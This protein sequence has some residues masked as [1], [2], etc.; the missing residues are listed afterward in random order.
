MATQAKNHKQTI[1]VKTNEE[2]PEPVEVIAQSIITI[3]EGIEKINQ[4]R[5]KRRAVL[6][7]INDITGVGLTTIEKVLDA[8]VKLKDHYIKQAPIKK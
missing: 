5:L 7:L 2:N 8:A 3:S 6:L 4:S 1:T